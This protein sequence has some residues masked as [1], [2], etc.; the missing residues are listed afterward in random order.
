MKLG[1]N[2]MNSYAERTTLTFTDGCYFAIVVYTYL[3]RSLIAYVS[4]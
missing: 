1:A 3:R 2:Y 4:C